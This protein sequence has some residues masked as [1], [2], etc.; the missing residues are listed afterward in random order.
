[1][2]RFPFMRGRKS[3]RHSFSPLHSILS[4]QEERYGR[5]RYHDRDVAD[6]APNRLIGYVSA[7]HSSSY[8]QHKPATETW[9]PYGRA[10][11]VAIAVIMVVIWFCF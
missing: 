6:A 1:M 10:V 9:R 2:V 11:I 7:A 3:H 8:R 5:R 4:R